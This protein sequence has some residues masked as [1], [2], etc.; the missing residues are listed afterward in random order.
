LIKLPTEAW[1]ATVA[2]AKALFRSMKE[3]SPALQTQAAVVAVAV[4][5]Q[6]TA[7]LES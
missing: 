3:I 6:P 7:A 5:M 1:A 4:L 2:V